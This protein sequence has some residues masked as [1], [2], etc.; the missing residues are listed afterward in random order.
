MKSWKLIAKPHADVLSGRMKQSDFAAD[1]AKVAAGTAPAEYADAEKFFARTYLTKGLADLLRGVARRLSGAGGDPV[2]EL[3]T[4]FGGGKTHTLL[5]VYHLA[6]RRIPTERLAGVPALLDEAGIRDLPRARVAVFDGVNETAAKPVRTSEGLELRPVWGR[7]A[8]GLL[9]AEGYER[10]AECDRSGTAPGKGILDGLLAD[11]GPCAILL[12]EMVAFYRQLQS[13]DTLPA[14]TWGA[15]LTFLQALM[16]SVKASSCAVLIA[17]IPMSKAEAGDAFGWKVLQSLHS[18]FNRIGRPVAPVNADEGYEIVRRRLF[19]P[20]EDDEAVRETCA[21]FAEQYRRGGVLFPPETRETRYEERMRACYPV[22]PEV[23]D[24]LYHEWS[25]LPGFQRTRGVLQLLAL[26]VRD[27]WNG[28]GGEPL[29]LP[30]SLPLGSPDV[31]AHLR[32]L[33][34]DPAWG[35]VIDA[36]VDGPSAAPVRLD[37]DTPLFAPIHAARSAARAI[38]FDTAPGAGVAA[39]HG[40]PEAEVLLG[41]TAPG[42]TPRHYADAVKKLRD[43]LHYLFA[44][45]DRFRFDT[46]PNLRREME[47]RRE[48]ISPG[49]VLNLVRKTLLDRFGHSPF[50]AG[51]HVFAPAPD[52]PDDV[53]DGVRVA[54]LPA[55]APYA[56]AHAA[57]AFEAARTILLSHGPAA[58][59]HVNRL[60]FLAADLNAVSRVDDLARSALA[61]RQIADEIR[62]KRLNATVGEQAQAEHE[63]DGS[64]RTLARAVAECWRFALVPRRR[65]GR[66]VEFDVPKLSSQAET[67]SRALEDELR[68]NEDVVRSWS[69]SFLKAHLE[70]YYF[71]GGA[72]GGGAD[73]VSVQRVW[74]DLC[75][76]CEPDFRRLQSLDVFEATVRDGLSP[77]NGL[78]GYAQA[79]RGGDYEGFAFRKEVFN[80]YVDES[81]VLVRAEAAKAYADAQRT[82]ETSERPATQPVNPGTPDHSSPTENPSSQPGAPQYRHYYASVALDPQLAVAR[83]AQIQ[84]E[85]LRLF[86]AR[87]DAPVTVKL[88]IEASS[89]TPFDANLVRAVRE[90]ASPAN[91]DIAISEFTE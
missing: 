8:Y 29:I 65:P 57:Q 38:F 77:D 14:G 69:P 43:R 52:V 64:L 58:R 87:P 56:A 21:A 33:L 50:V 72:S 46:R 70:K 90:N 73:E 25:T 28:E 31:A 5:A 13:A 62:E 44:E 48:R 4:N 35:A 45:N 53:A 10:V 9:G 15:N 91:L 68:R 66:D 20:V 3:Q 51:A 89:P 26:V 86:N 2:L 76:V 67:I 34:P 75:D 17:T 49:D 6:S 82:A 74:N 11:A 24:R 12:D 71:K 63:R 54:V 36:E 83:V 80:V 27:L 84:D 47:A 37:A 40:V 41:C 55:D 78:F 16:E 85:L 88:D 23:F 61:W 39:A 1:L 19:E 30:G 42:E 60:V 81:A 18:Y 22:H 59:R 32:S 7:L 79:K